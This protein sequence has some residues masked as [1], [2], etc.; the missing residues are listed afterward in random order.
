MRD[1]LEAVAEDHKQT[2]LNRLAALIPDHRLDY[3][4]AISFAIDAFEHY[5]P[6]LHA[7]LTPRQFF[8][9][10]DTPRFVWILNATVACQA[11]EILQ[12]EHN[13][14]DKRKVATS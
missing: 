8:R 1:L 11:F 12:L 4:E 7:T 9:M 14:D 2:T 6:T 5:D 10:V 13:A 3:S